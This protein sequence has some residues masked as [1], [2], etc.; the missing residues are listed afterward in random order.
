MFRPLFLLLLALGALA[1]A[2]AGAQP[3]EL[4]FASPAPPQSPINSRGIAEW[5]KDVTAASGN[6]ISIRVMAGPALASF[7]NVYDRVLKG[8]ADIGF[9]T[10]STVAGQ[11]R[12]SEVATL[13]FESEGPIEVA[14]TLWRAT[15]RGLVAEDYAAIKPLAL[16]SFPPSLLH[17]RSKPIKILTDLKGMKIG[18]A[19]RMNGDIAASLGAAPITLAPP[20]VYQ[21]LSSGLIDGVMIAWTAVDSF[22]LHEVTKHH[23]NV[24]L[25]SST[26]YIIINKRSY[27]RLPPQ[28][29]A[30][31]DKYSGE[32][33][34]RRMGNVVETLDNVAKYQV[35]NLAGHSFEE[36]SPEERARWRKQL[37]TI[38]AAWVKATPNGAAILAGYREE[39]K[40]FRSG[41]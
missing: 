11:F 10:G 24:P 8:V 12:R 15:E 28:A 7:E 32:T 4:R 40:K 2:P 5:V 36:A 20:E 16:F 9:G 1:T 6:T 14:V 39:V 13:P 19:G 31:I 18:G 22:K 35:R 17:T 34:S 30:A 25:S 3:V 27:E 33:F 29:R 38:S 37:D 41:R 23:F 26:A 21:S